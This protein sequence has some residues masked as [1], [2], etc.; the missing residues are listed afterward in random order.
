MIAPFRHS[1][2][3]VNVPSVEGVSA[4][5]VSLADGFFD[6]A[7]VLKIRVLMEHDGQVFHDCRLDHLVGSQI[8]YRVEGVVRATAGASNFTKA[9][10]CADRRSDGFREC[11]AIALLISFGLAHRRIMGE[12]MLTRRC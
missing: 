11:G 10:A 9:L 12:V 1:A 6:S 8:I 3:T 2:F 4:Q 5:S 7:K